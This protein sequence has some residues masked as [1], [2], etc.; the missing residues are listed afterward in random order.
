MSKSNDIYSKTKRKT[1]KNS[2]KNTFNKYGKNTKR[3]L[4]IN[5]SQRKKFKQNQYK[6]VPR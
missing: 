5:L 1:K 2:K 3:S 6:I 4:R